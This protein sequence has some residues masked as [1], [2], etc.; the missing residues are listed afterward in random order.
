MGMSYSI[1]CECI[2]C[3]QSR[4]EYHYAGECGITINDEWLCHACVIK[5]FEAEI[6]RL[7]REW[8]RCLEC[9]QAE[10]T[11]ERSGNELS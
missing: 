4:N 7:L 11:A 10:K 3:G 1:K 5:D 2:K 6:D 9:L 8:R